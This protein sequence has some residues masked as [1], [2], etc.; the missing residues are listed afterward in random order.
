M[1]C[2]G[3]SMLQEFLPSVLRAPPSSQQQSKV[4]GPPQRKPIRRAHH[5][6]S[7]RACRWAVRYDRAH[8]CRAHE[9]VAR[10]ASHHRKR[11]WC[12]SGSIGVGRVARAAGDGYTLCYG[13]L[14]THV[15]NGA[16]FALQ[17]NVLNDFEPVSLLATQPQLIVAKK[18]M[19]AKDLTELIAW[20][21]ENPDKAS[22]GTSGAGSP[23]H[24]AGV[25]LPEGNGHPFSIRA[26]SRRQ[27]GSAGFAGWTDRH[28]DR[29]GIQFSAT[30]A[31][32]HRSRRMR[33]QPRVGLQ[34]RPIFQPLTRQGCPDSTRRSGMQSLYPRRRRRS[35]SASSMPRWWMRWPMGRFV[36]GS[37]ISAWSSS[38]ASS[39]RRRRSATPQGRDREVVANHQ[40][41]EYQGRVKL[42][43][44]V[45]PLP[46]VMLW[47]APPPA[48]ECRR[49]G[50]C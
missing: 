5:V 33:S 26:L 17:Y 40:G 36:S 44:N 10:S 21:K 28:D 27:P 15:V 23:A 39:R 24:V 48:H 30:C 18:A 4:S 6:W 31:C 41:G 2:A 46:L 13:R 34:R 1:P 43:S 37:P 42:D 45:E 49:C 12:A 25:L 32:R 19:P 38:H 50:R 35:S 9:G 7:C 11:D 3:M 20:L 16:V 8:H 22:Q 47:T 14:P 29:P